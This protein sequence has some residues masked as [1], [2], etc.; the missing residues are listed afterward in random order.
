MK[1]IRRKYKELSN[2][3]SFVFLG[4]QTRDALQIK[5]FLLLLQQ[6]WAGNG[7]IRIYSKAQ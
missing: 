6:L 3:K 2:Y 7:N 5:G 1:L 4:A